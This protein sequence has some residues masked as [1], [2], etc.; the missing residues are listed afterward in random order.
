MENR[1]L[2]EPNAAGIDIGARE[3]YVAVPPDRDEHAVRVFDSFTGDLNELADWLTACG[4]TAA[5]FVSWLA[6]CPDNDISGGRVLGR[7]ARKAHNRAGQLFRM[8]AY[9]L[10]R[11]ATPLGDYLRRMKAKIGP[12]V[13]AR[14]AHLR[15]SRENVV[16]VVVRQVGG[17]YA[18]SLIRIVA[19]VLEERDQLLGMRIRQR[20]QQH[21]VDDAEDGAV[22]SDSEGQRN[23]GD[24]GESRRARQKPCGKRKLLHSG[25]YSVTL[26]VTTRMRAWS[27]PIFDLPTTAR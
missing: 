9:S 24:D 20:T 1:P 13:H 6:L 23:Y 19:L 14:R 18:A 12:Q 11:S 22:H 21:G 10:D 16:L 8:A 17:R 26:A 5:C 7:G 3:I 2:L 25:I 27:V 4:V 15:D